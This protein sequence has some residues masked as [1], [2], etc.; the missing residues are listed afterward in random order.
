MSVSNRFLQRLEDGKTLLGLC[1]MYPAAGIVEGMCQ[2]WDFVW[3]DCQHG[4]M[5]YDAAMASI[6]AAHVADVDTLLRVPGHEPG[7]IGP[8]LDLAPSAIMIPM[9]NTAAQAEAI[10][11]ATHFPPRGE[12]SYGGR[13]VIDLYGRDYYK[14]VK[15]AVVAQIETQ[16][17]AANAREIIETDGI[18]LLF[19]GPDDMKVSL[20]LPINTAPFA[21]DALIAA[22]KQTADAAQAA[23]KF[24]C[25]VAANEQAAK[26]ATDM[27]FQVLVGGGDIAFMR[28]AAAERL[29]VLRGATGG[30]T[31]AAQP[32]RRGSDVY[33]G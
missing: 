14:D 23:G 31:A 28:T 19:F 20:D 3:I 30:D 13:R 21:H 27:G 4:E 15:T 24:A 6:R 29:G 32:V 17:A 10:A 16:E 2:G 1:N 11:K 12:R 33:G 8:Y 18:D 5:G 7:V 9:V 26:A 22:M 25:C